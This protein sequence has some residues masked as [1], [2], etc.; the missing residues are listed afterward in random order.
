M[1]Y[2]EQSINN[3]ILAKQYVNAIEPIYEATTGAK[4]ELLLSIRDVSDIAFHKGDYL[5]VL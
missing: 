1:Q 2:S 3:V 5:W 4:S